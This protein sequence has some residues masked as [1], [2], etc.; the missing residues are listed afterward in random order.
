MPPCPGGGLSRSRPGGPC[1]TPKH[2]QKAARERT[3]I[4]HTNAILRIIDPLYFAVLAGLIFI[5]RLGMRIRGAPL[6]DEKRDT[7]LLRAPNGRLR[8]VGFFAPDR[9]SACESA[10]YPPEEQHRAAS[11]FPYRQW[12]DIARTPYDQF[13]RKHDPVP[14]VGERPGRSAQTTGSP[15]FLPIWYTCSR[16]TYAPAAGRAAF[17]MN[18]PRRG[19]HRLRCI[20]VERIALRYARL[21]TEKE[22]GSS[23]AAAVRHTSGASGSPRTSLRP[24]GDRCV[25]SLADCS[26]SVAHWRRC[27][28]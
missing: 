1:A 24:W 17:P 3:V 21:L 22:P 7:C 14:L 4:W 5:I 23:R 9:I 19:S 8:I 25:G 18:T 10:G 15:P 27:F 20:G 16:H 13:Q 11:P 26:S 6:L 28:S 2:V 12:R